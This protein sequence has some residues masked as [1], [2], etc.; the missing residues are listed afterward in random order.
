MV[1][2]KWTFA[3]GFH[4][5]VD[6]DTAG[7]VCEE[8]RENGRLTAA[9]LV[10]VSRPEDAP[11]HKAFEWRDDVAAE[12]WREQQARTIIGNLKV[13]VEGSAEPVKAYFNLVYT[14][15]EY[16]SIETILRNEDETAVLL[17]NAL[18][19][20]NLFREKYGKLKAL[21]NVIAAMD[22]LEIEVS[23]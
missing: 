6:A 11:L 15:P 19:D 4:A 14:E 22:Q 18:R 2:K 9:N 8:L 7:A 13:F 21:A 5:K 10:E 17:R 1:V 3:P 16:K 23:A 20:M 12:K